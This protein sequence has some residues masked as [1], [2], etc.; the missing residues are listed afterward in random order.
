MAALGVHQHAV[1]QV[2][3]ALPLEPRALGP[4]GDVG[5]VGALQHQAL[6]AVA[7]H[8][9]A[10]LGA[11][12]APVAVNWT[13]GERSKR[14]A[15]LG[16]IQASSRA[17]RSVERQRAQ[18]LA[19]EPQRVVE[20]DVRGMLLQHLGRHGLAVQ[21]LLQ[22]VER[23]DRLL[24]AA[25]AARRRTRRRSRSPRRCR[26]RRRRCPRRRGCRAASRRPRS[27]LHAD[28][29]P[30]PF[31]AEVRRDRACR[32]RRAR[33]DWPASPAGTAPPL[34]LLGFGPAFQPVRTAPRRA[35]SARARPPRPRRPAG[36]RYWPTAC[37]ASRAET[38]TRSAPVSS[39]SS[40]QRPVA[41]SAVEPALEDRRR[42]RLGGALQGLDHLARASAAVRRRGLALARSAP[43]S[44]RDRRH[45]RR[46]SGTA[47]GRSA[48]R[49]SLRSSAGLAAAKSS[50]AG[51]RRQ[52]PAAIGIGRLRR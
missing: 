33:S 4:A 9:L 13:S 22:V 44:R 36:R 46:T 16:A 31:G 24:A 2:R 5:R 37:L 30:F 27:D 18:V 39:L 8:L 52:R 35:A 29:V 6:D 21:P 12:C 11:R 47:P 20:A 42:L 10:Q 1:D 25:P 15:A 48:P 3:V 26:G 43:P 19:L 38:P 34:L 32:V 45:S 51:Q 41:S 7:A 50:V 28:A 49:R 40:A 23:R 17:R 14:G